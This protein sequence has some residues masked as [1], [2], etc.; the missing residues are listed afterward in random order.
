M[1]AARSFYLGLGPTSGGG[2]FPP[3]F[4]LLLQTPSVRKIPPCLQKH[5]EGP[6]YIGWRDQEKWWGRDRQTLWRLRNHAH[7]PVVRA[8]P[9]PFTITGTWTEEGTGGLRNKVVFIVDSKTPTGVAEIPLT[10]IAVE[11]F[12]HQMEL[13]GPGPWLFPSSQRPTEHQTD[14]KTT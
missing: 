12:R 7:R 5:I 4:G 6:Q 13:A 9:E 3:W 10:D 2:R 14:F 8:F 11:A 1:T